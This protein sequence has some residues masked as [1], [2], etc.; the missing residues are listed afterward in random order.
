MLLAL[1]DGQS[2]DVAHSVTITE[3]IRVVPTPEAG[4][5]E[6]RTTEV[7]IAMVRITVDRTFPLVRNLGMVVATTVVAVV[8]I[9]IIRHSIVMVARAVSITR[10]A[11]AVEKG[12]MMNSH[13][14]YTPGPKDLK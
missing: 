9:N 13:T 1:L 3:T 10:A 5:K 7:G 6:D 8:S 11:K 14:P 2:S 4:T 12:A